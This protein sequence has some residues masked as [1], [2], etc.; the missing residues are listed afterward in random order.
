[1]TNTTLKQIECVSKHLKRLGGDEYKQVDYLNRVLGKEKILSPGMRAAVYDA[2]KSVYTLGIRSGRVNDGE[3]KAIQAWEKLG[4]P[5]K[6]TEALKM[7]VDEW[8]N[9]TNKYFS[10]YAAM[11]SRKLGQLERAVT[12]FERFAESRVREAANTDFPDYQL[13]EYNL[14]AD[15]LGMAGKPEKVKELWMGAANGW[16]ENFV[17]CYDP[18]G[19]K[20]KEYLEYAV[21]AWK[22]AG[23]PKTS[24]EILERK[25]KEVGV[26]RDRLGQLTIPVGK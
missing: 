17:R 12:N 5:K 15:A 23:M 14:A 26:A 9:C 24:E 6:A 10:L 22:K 21:H 18:N 2:F 13:E 7:A 25:M 1:M 19:H 11:A 16:E 3:N 8:E 20:R 4:K